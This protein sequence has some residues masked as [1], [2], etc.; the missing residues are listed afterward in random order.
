MKP[1]VAQ[2]WF[3]EAIYG[4]ISASAADIGAVSDKKKDRNPGF[5]GSCFLVL[6]PQSRGLSEAGS[7]RVGH[8]LRKPLHP[9]L[10]W[11]DRRTA[12]PEA[13]KG[14]VSVAY[15]WKTFAEGGEEGK[16]SSKRGKS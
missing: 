12:G 4:N 14:G 3:L 2:E 7:S 10:S 5:A 11:E 13:W 1:D 8:A 9:W 16:A 6:H 15:R